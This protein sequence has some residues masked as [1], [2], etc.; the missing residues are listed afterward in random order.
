[1]NIFDKGEFS[2]GYTRGTSI[3]REVRHVWI[4]GV[5]QQLRAPHDFLAIFALAHSQFNQIA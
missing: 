1:M 5:T 3:L 2:V 4:W